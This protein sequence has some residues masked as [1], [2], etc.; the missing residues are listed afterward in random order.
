MSVEVQ[1]QFCLTLIFYVSDTFQ[2]NLENFYEISNYF[3]TSKVITHNEAVNFVKFSSK[4]MKENFTALFSSQS[5]V[6]LKNQ[7]VLKK[8]FYNDLKEFRD[9]L[10]LSKNKNGDPIL[11]CI[12]CVAF[13]NKQKHSLCNIGIN[14]KETET[15]RIES[16]IKC[17]ESTSY[18]LNAKQEAYKNIADNNDVQQV[19]IE[20]NRLIAAKVIQIVLYLLTSGMYTIPLYDKAYQQNLITYIL[21]MSR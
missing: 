3:I 2:F 9:Y 10:I 15:K 18:H 17:H 12:Y 21:Q 6:F 13:Q 11:N 1:L 8:W 5:K 4:L 20:K 16:S 7:V 14:L 19:S